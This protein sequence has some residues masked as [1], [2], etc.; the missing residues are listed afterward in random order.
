MNIKKCEKN[1]TPIGIKKFNK[2]KVTTIII[3]TIKI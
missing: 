3:I 2:K 1:L